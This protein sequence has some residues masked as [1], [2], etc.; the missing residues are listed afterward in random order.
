MAATA[1]SRQLTLFDSTCIIAG[2]VIGAGIYEATPNVAANVTSVSWLLGVWLLG[3]MISLAGALCYVELATT[4]P[5]EGGDYVYLT[6]AFGRQT[7]FLFAWVEYWIVRPGNVGMMAFVLARFANE[8]LKG[9]PADTGDTGFNFVLYAAGTIVAITFLNVLGVRTGKTTQNVLTAVKI[10]GLLAVCGV[11]FTAT[12]TAVAPEASSTSS[13]PE[14]RLALIF[15][16]F[17]YGGWNSVSYV[18]AEVQRPERNILWSLALGLA[19]ITAVYVL[20]NLAFVHALGLAGASRYNA[21]DLLELRYGELGRRVMA[22]L[23]CLSCLG[24]INGTLFTG[25]RIYYAVG[26]EHR[27]LAWLGRWS[28]QLDSPVRALVLQAAAALLWVVVFGVLDGESGFQ[29]LLA[30]TTP[31]FWLFAILI[32]LSVFVLRRKDPAV[33]RPHKIVLYPLPPVVFCLS[34]AFM[35]YAA[36]D[37]AWFNWQEQSGQLG[38]SPHAICT[39]VV[40]VV[41]LAIAW[42]EPRPR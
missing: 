1:P 27:L 37:W 24:A 31:V 8:L 13:A 33:V 4:Y 23:V 32:G 39:L 38:W 7:G 12:A 29:R 25:S 21:V 16:L 19:L 22:V 34:S 40:V 15:V 6:R 14:I 36:V 17:T 11:G 35:L 2:I 28:G 10:A 42:W 20:V 30:F 9:S 3:G 18:A 26:T 5:Y 41:G